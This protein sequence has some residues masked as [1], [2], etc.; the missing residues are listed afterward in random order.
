V[1]ALSLELT[2]HQLEHNPTSSPVPVGG[3]IGILVLLAFASEGIWRLARHIGVIAHEGAH[4][5]AGWCMGRKVVSVKLNSD[6]TGETVT[7][8]SSAGMGLIITGFA[9][10]LGP[11]I[12]GV[13]AAGLLAHHQ[14]DAVLAV[15]GVALFVMLFWVRNSF[16]FV[17]VL[18]N[19]GLLFLAVKYGSVKLQTIAAYALSWFL[20]LSGVRFVLMHGSGAVDADILRNLTHVPRIVWATLWLVITVVALWAGGRLLIG[21]PAQ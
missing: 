13:F 3:P 7:S 18:L 19:C 12:C 21:A 11:S 2:R 16:G 5:L 14:L 4:A 20:L 1:L 15:T 6:A 10:Y 9:G 17:S 8:G